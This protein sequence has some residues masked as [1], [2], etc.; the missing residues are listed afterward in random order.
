MKNIN[1][2]TGIYPLQKTL[3]FELIPQGKTKETFEKWITELENNI[4]NKNNLLYQDECRADSY[5]IVKKIIDEYHKYFIEKVLTGCKLEQLEEYYMYYN[6]PKKDDTEKKAFN[7]ISKKLR[8]QI[9][10]KFSKHPDYKRLFAKELIKEDLP[11]FITDEE[12][13][14]HVKEFENFTTYFSGFHQNRANMYS[15]DDK[16][17]AI[18]YRLIHQNLPKFIDNMKIFDKIKNSTLAEKFIII[19]SDDELG[20]IIQLSSIYDAFTIDF[21]N[22]TLTQKGIDKYN[23]LIGGYTSEDGKTKIKGLNEYINLYN[24]TAKKENKLPFLKILYKQIL[25]DRTTASFIPEDYENDNEVIE[26]IKT[27]YNRL[28]AEIFPKIKQ[29]LEKIDEYDLNKIY[30]R[31][32]LSITDISQKISGDWSLINKA[33]GVWYQNNYYKGKEKPGSDKYDELLR[34][35]FNNQDSFSIGFLNNCLKLIDTGNIFLIEDYFKQCGKSNEDKT[36]TSENIFDKITKNYNKIENL[37]NNPYPN[38]KKLSQEKVEV[39][40]IKDLLD[41]I[42]ELQ[43]FIKPLAGKGTESEK[44]EHFY[45]EFSNLFNEL[46]HITSLYNKVRNYMTRKPYSIEKIKLNF[47]SSYFLRGWAKDYETK[48]GLLFIKDGKYYL[49]INNKKLTNI[50][51][52]KLSNN[53]E[54]NPAKRIILDFQKPDMKN[55]PRLFI[56]SKGD[57]FA[58]AVAKYNLPINKIID[59]YDSGKFKTEYRKINEDEYKQSLYKIIDYYKEGFSKHESYKHYAFSWKDTK[60]YNDISEFYKDLENSCYQIIEESINW[61]NLIELIEEGKL[62]L[63]QIYNKD[64]S[65]YSKGTPNMHT[66]YWKMLFDE[67]NLK[68]IV[69]KLNGEAEVFF[70][71]SSI[72]KENTV[73]HKANIAIPNKNKLNKQKESIFN[74]DIIKDKR[75]TLDKFQFHVPIT[76]NFKTSGLNNINNSV[77]E[78]IKENDNVH[79][80]GIDRGE[81][82]LLYLS[83]I[84]NKGNIVKQFSLNEIINEYNDNKYVTN[85]HDLLDKREG[86]RDEERKNWTTIETIKELKEGY[87]SQVVHI[88]SKLMIKYNAIVVLEDLNMG[89]KRGRQKVEKQVYQKFEKMLIDKLNYLVD[90]NKKCDEYGG[91]LKAYQLTNKFESF[92]KMSKQNGFLFYIP[93]WNTSKIDPVTGFVNFIDTRY[94]SIEKAKELFNKFE[95]IRYNKNKNYFEFIIKNYSAFNARAEETRQD[96]TICTYST[97]IV[98]FRNPEKNSQWDSKEILLTDEFNTLFKS[99]NINIENDIK[100][101]ISNQTEKKFFEKLLHLLRLTLQM[102]NSITGTET[103]YLISPVADANGNFYDSRNKIQSLP[104]NADANGAYNIARKGQWVIEQIKK[105]NTDLKQIKLAISNREWLQFVQNEKK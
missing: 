53:V 64:F 72:K 69:Y 60:K 83:L 46:E 7:E 78:F 28:N 58:P 16:S 51:K 13:K 74:Y 33:L 66:L 96:W 9:A 22:E 12:Q 29:L 85:Y 65:P 91:L 76:M 84:D 97:R 31:N 94:S 42:K 90:K 5:K 35:Y 71:K 32:D 1:D 25:S 21:F 38:N 102:R 103:D 30:L 104:D 36:L 99:Y 92:Q 43:W 52:A 93:A 88:I 105:P 63:F 2:F 40:G 17:T 20:P 61:D 44:D 10:E 39:A 82:H 56:R 77:N 18:A 23:H 4:V 80:I 100:I 27:L 75:Y 49:G 59:I 89:F 48:A 24:Q 8:K 41:S 81:R 50:E 57:N 87:I 68:D 34:K 70:R 37:L 55:I 14:R 19:N 11:N 73:I 62:Y 26:S 3:R 95:Q 98:T 15:A 101:Q 45:G 54:E 79:I 6:I 67:A 86:K 47:E